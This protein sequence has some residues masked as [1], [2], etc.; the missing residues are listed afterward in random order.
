MEKEIV[1]HTLKIDQI[2]E[3]LEAIEALV[4]PWRSTL[5]PTESGA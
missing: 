3:A 4:P 1:A 2:E 5:E